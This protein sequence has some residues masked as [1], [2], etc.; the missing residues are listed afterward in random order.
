MM[1]H[2]NVD[3]IPICQILLRYLT[4][5]HFFYL[6]VSNTSLLHFLTSKR[7]YDVFRPS[8][9]EIEL[10]RLTVQAV[11]DH[12]ACSLLVLAL[13]ICSNDTKKLRILVNAVVYVTL[14]Y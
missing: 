7:M 1:I 3:R 12:Q 8:S 13:L 4:G 14:G 2:A 6:V 9:Y 10:L 5:L 11:N